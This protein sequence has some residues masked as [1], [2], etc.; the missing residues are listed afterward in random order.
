MAS[1]LKLNCHSTSFK[2]SFTFSVT[3]EGSVV[4]SFVF[5]I[6]LVTFVAIRDLPYSFA[7]FENETESPI[8][9]SNCEILFLL[10][11]LF[12]SELFFNSFL[13]LFISS[14]R[15][16]FR[17]FSATI[18]L[19]TYL[20]LSFSVETSSFNLSIRIFDLLERLSFSN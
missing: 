10:C 8:S 5:F 17:L 1:S 15:F 18:T 6:R 13:S 3:G 12:S 20:I 11:S 4:S 19:F 2:S 9:F 14:L 7:I 16:L